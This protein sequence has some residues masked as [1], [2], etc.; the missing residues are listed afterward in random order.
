M[1]WSDYECT[2]KNGTVWYPF[3]LLWSSITCFRPENVSYE[4]P[5]LQ[6]VKLQPYLDYFQNTYSKMKTNI[7]LWMYTPNG[8]VWYP[9]CLLWSSMTC[10]RPENVCY[11]LP[12]LQVV[13]L[14]P[15]LDYFQ[16]TYSKMKNNI[17]L[18]MYTPNGTVWYP[19]C[20]L[21][22]SI[23]CFRPE[24]V[25]YELPILQVVKLQPYPCRI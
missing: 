16:N 5:I 24:N 9:F 2:Y 23:T 11:K 10:F 25:S 22:S 13:K 19:F 20:L 4:L 18:W 17:R 7:R 3:C 12:I 6:V 8:T 14:Q 21:W 15:Y 1:W